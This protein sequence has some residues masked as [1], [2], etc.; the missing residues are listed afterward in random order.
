MRSVKR[1]FSELPKARVSGDSLSER[2]TFVLIDSGIRVPASIEP[3]LSTFNRG[4]LCRDRLE[5]GAQIERHVAVERCR[6]GQV[7]C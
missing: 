6:H 7:N 4:E 3:R 2:Q 1:Y 5:F